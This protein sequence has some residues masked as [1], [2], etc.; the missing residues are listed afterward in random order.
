MLELEHF[1][2]LLLN[3]DLVVIREYVDELLSDDA[4]RKHVQDVTSQQ[5]ARVA[6]DPEA[7]YGRRLGWYVIIRVLQPNFVVETGIDKGLGTCVI[8]SALLKNTNEGQ[9]GRLLAIDIDPSTGWLVGPPY[10]SVTEIRIDD[11]SRA[12]TTVSQTIDLFI[13]DSIHTEEFETNELK[14][15][16]QKMAPA[17]MMMSDNAHAGPAL[18]TFAE[19]IGRYSYFWREVPEDHYFPGG[20]IGAI[21]LAQ[22]APKA[23]PAT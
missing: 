7:R 18:M 16:L 23:P 11:S 8:A 17:G 4:L 19:S 21:N 12:L 14:M 3:T 15:V 20:G 2:S 1:L 9:P 22:T 5:G 13:H 6:A 10:D